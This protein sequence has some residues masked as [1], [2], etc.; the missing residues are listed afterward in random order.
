MFKTALSK[1]I[2]TMSY[3]WKSEKDNLLPMPA[4]TLLQSNSTTTRKLRRID[5]HMVFIVACVI[6]FT[7]AFLGIAFFEAV[8]ILRIEQPQTLAATP[9]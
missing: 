2:P 5:G 9:Q 3:I 8:L 7:L 6:A 4:V 1:K